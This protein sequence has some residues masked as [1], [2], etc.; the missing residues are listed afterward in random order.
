[1]GTEA[2]SNPNFT[3]K[4]YS[5]SY[6]Q[7]T[8]PTPRNDGSDAANYEPD[9]ADDGEVQSQDEPGHDRQR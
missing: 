8:P 5:W 9:A 1:M 6:S 7:S 2:T 4:L 3:C